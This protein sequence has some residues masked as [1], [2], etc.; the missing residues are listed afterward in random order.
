MIIRLHTSD[1]R[2]LTKGTFNF[3]WCGGVSRKPFPS[4]FTEVRFGPCAAFWLPYQT[5]HRNV[6]IRHSGFLRRKVSKWHRVLLP[7]SRR[8]EP[9]LTRTTAC[10]TLLWVNN[11]DSPPSYREIMSHSMTE[12]RRQRILQPSKTEQR[13]KP[14]A[15]LKRIVP[16][17]SLGEPALNAQSRGT[18]SISS[19]PKSPLGAGLADPFNSLPGRLTGP[20]Q[21]LIHDCKTPRF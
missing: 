7:T 3:P 14:V 5:W 2:A 8:P 9:L 19:N 20:N 12:S 1:F 6:G 16:S 15:R 13:R 11:D 10:P 21:S 17:S 18:R 4:A